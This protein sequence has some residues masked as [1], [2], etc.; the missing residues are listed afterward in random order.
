MR[1]SREIQKESELLDAEY[2]QIVKMQKRGELTLF[3]L[4]DAESSEKT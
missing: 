2:H 4:P 1:Y 3:E